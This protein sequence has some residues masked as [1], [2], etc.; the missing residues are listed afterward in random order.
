M[1]VG[2]IAN[3]NKDQKDQSD[4]K[5]DTGSDSETPAVLCSTSEF[6][7]GEMCLSFK[8]GERGSGG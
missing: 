2:E 8:V 4:E 3:L 6:D 7:L 1:V 5:E